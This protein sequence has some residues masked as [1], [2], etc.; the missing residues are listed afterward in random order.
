MFLSMFPNIGGVQDFGDVTMTRT[1]REV[2]D[3]LNAG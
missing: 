3:T 1:T 2:L